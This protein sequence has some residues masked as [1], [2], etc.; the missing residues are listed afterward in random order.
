MVDATT[1]SQAI[2]LIVSQSKISRLTA[3]PPGIPADRLEALRDAYR[4]ATSDEEFLARAKQLELPID[5]VVGDELLA[6]V[7]VALQ[8][9]P[10]TVELIRNALKKD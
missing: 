9:S 2:A 5:P 8:Q 1:G 7:E 6:A 3:G 10:E 4:M